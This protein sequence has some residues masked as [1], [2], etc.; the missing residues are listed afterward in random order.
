MKKQPKII[1]RSTGDIMNIHSNQEPRRI[2]DM[3]SIG[4]E[5]EEV[6]Y[7]CLL[8]TGAYTIFKTK[9]D[10]QDSYPHVRFSKE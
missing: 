6:R 7:Q 8:F 4:N 9:E 3:A 10:I 1:Y 2:Y 5:Y